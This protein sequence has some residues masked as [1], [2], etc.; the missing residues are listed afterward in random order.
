MDI[1]KIILKATTLANSGETHANYHR[2][3]ELAREY[4]AHITGEGIDH[5]LRRFVSREEESM[6]EQR[7]ELTVSINPAIASSLIKPFQKVSRNN[8]VS[9]KYDFKNQDINDRVAL[10]VNEFNADNL[11][12]TDGLDV[13]L[14]TRFLELSFADPNSWIV[15]EWDAVSPGET[16]KPRPFE[17][18]SSQALNFEFI[19]EELQWL[20][21]RA[22]NV[23]YKIEGGSGSMNPSDV[24]I[25][26]ESGFK[27]TFYGIGTTVT[28]EQIDRRYYE[29][30]GISI[31]SNQEFIRIKNV[32]Y[33]RSVY[34]TRLEFVPAFR[35]GYSRDL[36]TK[37]KTF[38]NPF[39][40]AMPY[41][42]KALKTTSELDLTMAGHVFPQKLQYIEKCP[43]GEIDGTPTSCSS[44]YD[45]ISGNKCPSCN[46]RGV[47]TIASAQEAIYL[48]MPETKEDFIPLDDILIY[49]SP[50]IELVKFQDEYIRS[51]KQD[52][53]LAVYNSNM[54][55]VSDAQFAKTATEIDSN[56]EGIYDSLE[57]YTER[58]S[59]IWKRIVYTCAILSGLSPDFNEFEL[60]HA[61]PADPKLKTVA[62]LLSE[63][64]SANESDAPSFLRDILTRDIAQIMFNGDEEALRKFNVRRRFYPFNGKTSEEISISLATEYV[65][66][67]T[68]ILYANFEAIFTEIE[69]TVRNF[70]L[71]PYEKQT[72]IVDAKVSEFRAE[73]LKSD[74]IPIDFRTPGAEQGAGDGGESGESGDG[75]ENPGAG[76]DEN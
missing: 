50:P 43:G 69:K 73:I 60:I 67:Q 25:K 44:G 49:K 62:I 75:G 52:A 29:I 59:Q 70:Y 37:G 54:F 23:Y 5:Y 63:M 17:V 38:L 6:F 1:E 64:K 7:K 71:L 58:V 72:E 61:F 68:K 55:L 65:S 28:I 45:P 15:L 74:P 33:I 9:K 31:E 19:G 3:S 20:F 21:V 47:R 2:V 41:F 46:G 42:R 22:N 27:F 11:D 48:P 36:T 8:S 26:A 4:E 40:P 18:S 51:L 39:H 14:K 34:D 76:E 66:E 16:I 12:D 53:H 10:A 13:W 30:N 35:I 56:M 57:P 24:S 32:D